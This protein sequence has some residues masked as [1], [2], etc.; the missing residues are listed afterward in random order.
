MEGLRKLRQQNHGWSPGAKH[1]RPISLTIASILRIFGDWWTLNFRHGRCCHR[2][3]HQHAFSSWISWVLLL[4]FSFSAPSSSSSSSSS[5]WTCMDFLIEP[6][7]NP[8]GGRGGGVRRVQPPPTDRDKPS[9]LNP[10]VLYLVFLKNMF[11][12]NRNALKKALKFKL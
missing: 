1:R 8:G 11:P 3:C 9:C 12:I 6:L 10:S 4:L 7:K 5:P 2:Q